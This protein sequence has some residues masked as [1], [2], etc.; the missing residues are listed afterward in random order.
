LVFPL[1]TQRK[2]P[3]C[4]LTPTILVQ[5]FHKDV[6]VQW[7]KTLFTEQ[8]FVSQRKIAKSYFRLNLKERQVETGFT[9][10]FSNSA[11][12]VKPGFDLEVLPSFV[13]SFEKNVI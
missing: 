6:F 9:V 7:T 4:E 3:L 12:R 1:K 8:F 11:F 13:P 10:L 2:P 5:D